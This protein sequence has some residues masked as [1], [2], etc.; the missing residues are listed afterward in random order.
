VAHLLGEIYRKMG[1]NVEAIATV[2]LFGSCVDREDPNDIDI[3]IKWIEPELFVKFCNELLLEIA[4][5]IDIVNLDKDNS[6]SRLV[7]KERDENIWLI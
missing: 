4:M 1:D 6:F 2:T 3:G 7:E 5:P